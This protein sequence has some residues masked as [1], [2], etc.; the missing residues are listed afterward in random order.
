MGAIPLKEHAIFRLHY[1]IE[2][3]QKRSIAM[4]DI[5]PTM[6]AVGVLKPGGAENLVLNSVPTPTPGKGEVLIKVAAAG[7][8]RGDIVLREG[9]YQ[10]PPGMSEI[11]GF[12]VSGTIIAWGDDSEA[13]DCHYGLNLGS[14]VC[15]L[16]PGGGY[17]QYCLAPV[18]NLLPIPR[19]VPL[20]QASSLPEVYA[21]VW[22]SLFDLARLTSGETLL[23]HGGASGIG[24]AAIMLAKSYGAIV[25]ATAGT[26]DK[27]MVC[28]NLGADV[29]INYQMQDFAEIVSNHTDRGVDVI[30]DMVGGDYAMRNLNCLAVDGRLVCIGLQKSAITELDLSV[31]LFKRLTLI[32]S[33]LH[34]RDKAFRQALMDHLTVKVWPRIEIGD[35]RLVI[36]CEYPLQNVAEAHA[37]MDSGLHTGKI[38]LVMD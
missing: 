2:Q 22:S 8:N 16:V 23:V 10:R 25:I 3:V 26:D 14:T 4:G 11:L 36:D 31:I 17:A 38:I 27:C 13:H 28:K 32:G 21:T 19:G 33:V 29:S 20:I 24:T 37:R 7:I 15:A 9:T 6:R 35:I 1:L 12:E 34:S 5:P 18:E 30:L